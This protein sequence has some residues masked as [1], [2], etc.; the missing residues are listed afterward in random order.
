MPLYCYECPECNFLFEEFQH[1]SE[2][3]ELTCEQCGHPKCDRLMSFIHNRTKFNARDNFAKRLQPDVDR[4]MK[5]VSEGK[6]K[7]FLD[8]AGG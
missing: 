6:D 1:T 2:K 3:L 7:D 8:I 5:N 4:I